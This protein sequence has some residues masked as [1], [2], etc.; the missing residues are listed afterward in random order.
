VGATAKAEDD[1]SWSEVA[2]LG[3]RYGKYPLA[4]LLV[5]AFYWFLTEPSDT[6]APLQVVEAWMWHGITE[7]IWGADAVSLS[8]HNGW[9][10]RIDFH[11]SSFPGTFDS[12]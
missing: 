8:Q 2:A 11:H 4:L 12:V 1:M 6:L 5:E 7:M 3:L 9:T 10:T